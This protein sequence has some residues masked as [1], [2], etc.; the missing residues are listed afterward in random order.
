ML[1]PPFQHPVRGQ[2]ANKRSCVA[3]AAPGAELSF[4][5]PSAALSHAASALHSQRLWA[6]PSRST[7]ARQATPK[8][9]KVTNNFREY[10]IANRIDAANTQSR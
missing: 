2:A 10:G 5:V 9:K 7:K 1:K 6:F 8:K 4:K 3:L